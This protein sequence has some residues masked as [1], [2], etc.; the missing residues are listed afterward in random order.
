MEPKLL[1][2]VAVG[3]F[4]ATT[5]AVGAFACDKDAKTSATTAAATKEHACTPEMAA[6]CTPEMAA[7]CK[8]KSASAVTAS[9]KGASSCCMAGATTAASTKKVEAKTASSTSCA[10]G[11]G[12]TAAKTTCS[13]A[14]TTAAMGPAPDGK[15]E[16]VLVGGYKCGE[17]G[18]KSAHKASG[19][20]CDACA[21]MASC[22]DEVRA[23]GSVTQVV[24]L[25]NG[26]MYVYTAAPGKTRAL[27]SALAQ[28][29]E[30]LV[31]INTS[32][33]K[34]KLCGECKSMRGAMASGKLNREVV[35]IEGGSL[36]LMTSTDT[37]MVQKL[38]DMAN[39]A[40]AAKAKI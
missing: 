40:V 8:T 17:K 23:T 14:K 30:R 27:Q 26:I 6:K 37:K 3:V 33:D 36:T 24:K 9:A 35:N 18:S 25:K 2:R 5:W 29:N 32:G 15:V 12:A 22:D 10:Y 34:V 13:S 21:D 20:D 28:R 16:A 4:L 1:P 31:A 38:H 39:G 19:H 11:A 7:A